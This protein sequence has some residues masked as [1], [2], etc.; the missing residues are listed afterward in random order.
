MVVRNG[1]GVGPSDPLERCVK[2]RHGELLCGSLCKK[3]LGTSAGGLVHVM[4]RDWGFR[5]AGNFVSDAQRILQAFM[6]IRGF[7]VGVGDCVMS[8]AAHDRVTRLLDRTF[9]HTDRVRSDAAAAPAQMVDACV[10]KILGSMLTRGG[11]E[12]MKDPGIEENNISVM[13]ECGAKGSAINIAQILSCV[14]QQSVEGGR[15]RMGVGNRTLPCYRRGDDSAGARG[16]VCNSYGTGLT[17]QEYFFHAMGGREGLVDTAV[18]TAATGYI[19]R[20]LSKAQ[21]GLQVRYDSTVRNSNNDVI[22]F[23]YGGDSYYPTKLERS[24]LRTFKMDNAELRAEVVGVRVEWEAAVGAEAAE[25]W[26]AAA[27]AQF[28]TFREERDSVRAIQLQLE[29]AP[30][31]RLV[32][33]VAPARVLKRAAAK[34][35]RRATLPP[36]AHPDAVASRVQALLSRVQASRRPY[37][38]HLT[39][40]YIRTYLSL[41]N[42]MVVH[43]LS[44]EALDWVVETI[45]FHFNDALAEPGEMVGTVGASSIGAPCTQMTLNTFHTVP[46]HV[47]STFSRCV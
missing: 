5:R 36:P 3:T 32:M 43:C 15:I 10:T 28:Q 29:V 37:A 46:S 44:T 21:E 27:E 41:R 13:I 30:D 35:G 7:S 42:I 6:M 11:A 12:V 8:E 34:F 39:R 25:L 22:Q 38:T 24:A 1:L 2:V 23:Y 16:F 20:R 17:A 45:W 14:G 33:P 47:A 18:K 4:I 9:K 26:M 19:Q 40:I 31:G